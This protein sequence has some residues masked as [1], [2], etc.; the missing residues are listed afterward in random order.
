[1][2]TNES[3]SKSAL[4]GHFG[5]QARAEAI[6]TIYTLFA[7]RGDSWFSA[8]DEFY[9]LERMHRWSGVVASTT[10]M[11]RATF[12]PMLDDRFLTLAR[13]LHPRHKQNSL[14]LSMLSCALDEELSKIPLDGRP[15][16]EVY[17]RPTY[18]N[19][20]RIAASTGR[21]VTGKVAQ[22]LSAQD[23]LRPAPTCSPRRSPSTS[24]RRLRPWTRSGS[25]M[26]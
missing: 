21:K 8:T 11:E 2:F 20:L 15:S 7:S 22:K 10:T 26:C 19:R 17:A 24:A 12:N 25:S 14:F 16:P 6:D 9:L 5:D 3:V 1:M 4:A 18:A 23:G 13:G